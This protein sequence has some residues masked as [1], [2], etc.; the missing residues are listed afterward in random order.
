MLLPPT[1]ANPLICGSGG[2][3]GTGPRQSP[4]IIGISNAYM[5][6]ATSTTTT[7]NTIGAPQIHLPS[8]STL[9]SGTAAAGNIV[10]SGQQTSNVSSSA[11]GKDDR[12][13]QQQQHTINC[14]IVENTLLTW[15]L[16]AGRRVEH[17]K[18]IY[19]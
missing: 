11:I 4:D 13:R 7:A 19:L 5:A 15:L 8:T 18:L 14:N 3:V 1:M 6:A 16:P 17:K 12:D 2:G 10:G 9:P